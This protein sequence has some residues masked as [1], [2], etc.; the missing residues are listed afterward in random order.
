MNVIV[1]VSNDRI[2]LFDLFLALQHNIVNTSAFSLSLVHSN[3]LLL[4]FLPI[5][6]LVNISVVFDKHLVAVRVVPGRL[7]IRWFYLQDLFLT[8]VLTLPLELVQPV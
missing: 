1:I 3:Q 4:S 6:C 5:E 2:H 8:V 7:V